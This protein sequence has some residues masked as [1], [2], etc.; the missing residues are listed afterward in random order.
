MSEKMEKKTLN[1]DVRIFFLYNKSHVRGSINVSLPRALMKKKPNPTFETFYSQL[2]SEHQAVFDSQQWK[3]VKMYGDPQVMDALTRILKEKGFQDFDYI[4]FDQF[5][6]EH[7][8]K[9]YVNEPEPEPE[10]TPQ[11]INWRTAP[12][13]AYPIGDSTVY[14]G[15]ERVAV[16]E[17]SLIENRVALIINISGGANHLPKFK[18]VKLNLEDS[19]TQQFDPSMGSVSYALEEMNKAITNGRNV[20]VYCYAGVSRSTTFI[21]LYLI[22]YKNWTLSAALK[23][24]H[25]QRPFSTPN[26]G[27]M[28][29]LIQYEIQVH[30]TTTC[31][32]VYSPLKRCSAETPSPRDH[33]FP[34]V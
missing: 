25:D 11:P 2:S 10:H 29:Q 32:D 15:G 7:P 5:L 24:I 6:K 17:D 3:V 20:F 13:G 18:Y 8:E 9:C 33:S 31:P 12:P 22:G 4:D 16:K 34:L 1:I 19:P 27:F 30:G 28:T 21:I 23:L 14:H 26:I